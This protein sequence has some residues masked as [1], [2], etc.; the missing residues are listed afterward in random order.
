MS[1]SDLLSQLG[2]SGG[3][4][5]Q[6]TRDNTASRHLRIATIALLALVFLAPLMTYNQLPLTGEGSAQRQLGYL[7][8]LGLALFGAQPAV[9]GWKL[10]PL[11]L[12]LLLAL[13]W[14]WLSLAWAIDPSIGVRRLLLTTALIWT[15]F[16][17]VRFAG[18]RATVDVLKYG[19]LAGLVLNYLF[20]FI[21][22]ATGIHLMKDS[23]MPTALIGNWRGFMVHK[24]F[25]GAACAI[26]ILVF[27]L[28]RDKLHWA[29]RAAIILAAGYFLFRSQSK[30]SA[31]MVVLSLAAAWI[32][33]AF[34]RKWRAYLI[35]ALFIVG[36]IGWTVTSAYR[37]VIE[38]SYLD[39]A[40]FTGRGQIW[41][42]LIS[43]AKDHL[44][45]GTGFGSFWNIGPDSP[46]YLYGKGYVTL[47]SVGH[48]GYLDLLVTV[49]LPGLVLIVFATIVWPL[50]RLLRS[51]GIAAE[52][53]ALV[54]ALLLFCV[55]HNITE[56]SLFERDAFV[57][58]FMMFAVALAQEISRHRRKSSS[59]KRSDGNDL[60]RA[61][62]KRAAA[63]ELSAET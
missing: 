4:G 25:A 5:R 18:Y 23:A 11:P 36:A 13:G 52:Q 48:N 43:Y 34:S 61:M 17:V 10:V 21:D 59:G 22:P 9:A 14:C 20:V 45:L 27:L 6:S 2:T 24:N 40:A 15:I 29:L 28:D 35:P 37:N 51:E 56:S 30:T 49:G 44:L 58:M 3:G 16:I 60:L 38:S 7:L 50:L 8:I 53:G 26:T 31:G 62:K 33:Q 32:F 47:I 12:P 46:V 19:L 57:G 42:V 54:T 1:E 55:G 39:P 63:H 41:S